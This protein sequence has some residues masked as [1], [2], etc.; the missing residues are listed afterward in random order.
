MNKLN[1]NIKCFVEGIFYSHYISRL[2]NGFWLT[3]N[4]SFIFL[5]CDKEIV[6]FQAFIE[7]YNSFMF[8]SY[9]YQEMFLF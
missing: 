7:S 8:C 9:C 2:S 5:Q 4:T 3:E 1:I 6:M